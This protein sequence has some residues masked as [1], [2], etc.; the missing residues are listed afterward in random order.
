MQI[1]IRLAI[2]AQALFMLFVGILF[3]LRPVEAAANFALAPTSLLGHATLRA[4]M[5]GFFVSGALFALYAARQP[6]RWPLLVPMVLMACAILGRTVSFAVDGVV[7]GSVVPIVSELVML[8]ILV[9]GY[10]TLPAR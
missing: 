8:A 3:L 2:A 7:P 10:R 4:D 6:V 1:F 9:A 5:F